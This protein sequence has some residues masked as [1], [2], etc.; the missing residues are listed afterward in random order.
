[1]KQPQCII[2]TQFH[3]ALSR[4]TRALRR[5]VFS[6]VVLYDF[7]RSTADFAIGLPS[8]SSHFPAQTVTKEWNFLYLSESN[9]GGQQFNLLNNSR[10]LPLLGD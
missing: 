9:C 1:M 7:P 3:L 8:F 10:P 4:Q 6:G 5:A 2:V